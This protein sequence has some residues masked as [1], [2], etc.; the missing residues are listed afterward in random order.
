MKRSG[1]GLDPAVFVSRHAAMAKQK[2]HIKRRELIKAS[3]VK[4]KQKP[5]HDVGILQRLRMDIAFNI[6][7]GRRELLDML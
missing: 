6:S 5:E 2:V 1:W 7:Q 4:E 3:N